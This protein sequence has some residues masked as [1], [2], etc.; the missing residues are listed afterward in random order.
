[1]QETDWNAGF[2][3]DGPMAAATRERFMQRL[4]DEDLNACFGHYPWPG[5]GIVVQQE[6]RRVFRAL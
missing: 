6:G 1:M 2:D 4:E 3:N 5:F